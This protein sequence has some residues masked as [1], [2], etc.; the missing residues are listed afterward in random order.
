MS[1]V[2]LYLSPETLYCELCKPTWHYELRPIFKAP[3]IITGSEHQNRDSEVVLSVV[4][5]IA[6]CEALFFYL[7]RFR[8]ERTASLQF[9]GVG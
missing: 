1:E 2:A 4:H 8:E 6:Y 5:G 7:L 3:F 9:L